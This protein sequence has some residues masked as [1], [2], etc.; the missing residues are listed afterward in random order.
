MGLSRVRQ[1]IARESHDPGGTPGIR[2]RWC[3]AFARIMGPSL[4]AVV[5]A[6]YRAQ[7]ATYPRTMRATSERD[8]IS[9]LVRSNAADTRV[10]GISYVFMQNGFVVSSGG[11]GV[12]STLDDRSGGERMIT[13][14]LSAKRS[15]HLWSK[16][17]W[18]RSKTRGTNGRNR[19]MIERKINAIW[20]IQTKNCVGRGMIIS[21]E[22]AIRLPRD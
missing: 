15:G 17:K 13:E 20:I 3:R 5:N 9:S 14:Q 6:R 10:G 8:A 4:P 11:G 12:T 2:S 22:A 7:R 19:V 18:A 16:A 21:G 1:K